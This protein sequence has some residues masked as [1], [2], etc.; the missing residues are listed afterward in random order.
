MWFVFESPWQDCADTPPTQHCKQRYRQEAEGRSFDMAWP[1]TLPNGMIAMQNF[2]HLKFCE[3]PC[4][5][6]KS[7]DF[8][9]SYKIYS[10]F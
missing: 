10:F 7:V 1:L 5:K 6:K 2:H 9:A 4:D 8:V 3:G